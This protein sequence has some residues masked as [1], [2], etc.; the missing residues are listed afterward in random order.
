MRYRFRLFSAIALTVGLATA[1][2]NAQS[3]DEQQAQ[4]IVT[5]QLEAF[6]AGDFAQ[7][8]SYASPDIRQIFPTLDRFMSMVRNGY[9][10]V[11]R[12]G[13]YAFGQMERL[14][15][16]RIVWDVLIAAPDGSDYTAAYF[17]EQQADG[18]WKVDAVTM[19]KGAPGMI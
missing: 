7:A 15:D 11:L 2:A 17:L 18:T 13:N 6:L 4:D 12:P 9:L 8:Y 14:A 16:G 1:P 3:S 5:R 10:P 19:R